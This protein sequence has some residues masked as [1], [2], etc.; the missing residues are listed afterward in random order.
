MNTSQI[1]LNSQTNISAQCDDLHKAVILFNHTSSGDEEKPIL[2]AFIEKRI[3][4]VI[5]TVDTSWELIPVS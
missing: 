1:L 3:A 2:K 4:S 5:S